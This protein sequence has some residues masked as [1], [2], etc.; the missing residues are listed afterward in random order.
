MN[1][2]IPI[3]NVK[4]NVFLIGTQKLI[5]QFKSDFLM[6]KVGGGYE[7]FDEYI[8]NNHRLFER[9]LL[10][11][12]VKS[13]E[14]LE[15]VCYALMNDQRISSTL[16]PYELQDKSINGMQNLQINKR[17]AKEGIQ[18][19]GSNKKRSHLDKVSSFKR[20]P[21]QIGQSPSKAPKRS[22]INL[23][24]GSSTPTS[25]G[26]NRK[27]SFLGKNKAQ[28]G[29][30][31]V[32]PE[33]EYQMKYDQLLRELEINQHKKLESLQRIDG[34]IANVKRELKELKKK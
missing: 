15:W 31:E 7:K 4:N 6:I 24:A 1:V 30:G 26:R 21:S 5:L 14:S 25:A 33:Q 2:T 22:Y 8:P 11:H 18:A 3:I 34:E 12:M 20:S 32:T 29:P 16:N 13:Q 23:A 10:M 27:S 9:N 28:M 19:Y 17:L